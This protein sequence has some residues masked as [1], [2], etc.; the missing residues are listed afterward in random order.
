MNL[1]DY[2][3]SCLIGA[4]V[5]LLYGYYFLYNNLTH[6]TETANLKKRSLSYG[7]QGFI[8]IVLICGLFYY[9]ILHTNTARTILILLSFLTAFWCVIINKKV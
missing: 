4:T 6:S 9:F 3:T 7:L 1:F 8:R 5:G 2:L